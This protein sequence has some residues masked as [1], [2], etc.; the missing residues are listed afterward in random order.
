MDRHRS[1]VS[2]RFCLQFTLSFEPSW[3][4]ARQYRQLSV[5]LIL[6]IVLS[7]TFLIVSLF[8]AIP[9]HQTNAASMS[10]GRVLLTVTLNFPSLRSPGFCRPMCYKNSTHSAHAIPLPI[11]R[12]LIF[13][14]LLMIL[15]TRLSA[16]SNP[17]V[18]A[19]RAQT[20]VCPCP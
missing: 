8:S 2:R 5:W 15:A 16:Q 12:A 20:R 13:L 11:L 18:V 19:D 9:L 6:D 17:S 10:P 4:A 1:L 3:Q 7:T 14:G